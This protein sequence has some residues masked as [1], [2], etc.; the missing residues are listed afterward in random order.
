M[1]RTK[2]YLGSLLL[3]EIALLGSGYLLH[4]LSKLQLVFKD[5]VLLSVLFSIVSLITIIIFMRGQ[6]REPESQTMHSLVAVSLK[7]LVE[8]AVAF[9]WFFLAKKTG[10][11]NVVLFFVL[12]LA[13]TLFSILIILKTL[14][15]KTL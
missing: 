4:E 2:K 3:F 1:S 9:V 7:F 8:L 12:Y 13:F 5:L 11:Q 10:I 15:Y 6:N 14:K